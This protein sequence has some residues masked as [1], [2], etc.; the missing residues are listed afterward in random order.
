MRRTAGL[1]LLVA[2]GLVAC[3]ST[4]D[5]T[6]ANVTPD[7]LA[8]TPA[9]DLSP[10]KDVFETSLVAKE[11]VKD[12]GGP[13]PTRVWTYGGTMPGPLVDVNVGDELVAH[14]RNE[15]P[16]PTL[17]HWHGLR[18][19]AAMDGSPSVQTPVKPGESFDYRFRLKDAGLFWFHPHVRTGEQ[20]ERGLAGVIRVRGADEPDV[21]DERILVLDDVKLGDDGQ[22]PSYVDD[23]SKMLGREADTI[24]VNGV[25]DAVLSARPGALLRLR[26]LDVANGRFFNLKIA[27]ARMTVIG[28][29]GGRVAEPYETETVLLAPAERYDVV[30]RVP[31]QPGDLAITTE[32]YERGHDT[33]KNPAKKVATLRIQGEPVTTEKPL[34]KGRPIEKL[35]S[36]TGA[37]VKF[38]LDEG[39]TPQGELTFTLNGKAW[40]EV[41]AERVGVGEVRLLELENHAEMDHPFHVHGT[42]FQV[43][44]VNGVPASRLVEKDTVIVP[45]KGKVTAVARF[46]EPG[47]WMV[48]CHINEHSDSGMMGEI[49]VGDAVS[50]AHGA[51]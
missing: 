49:L 51:H 40:P 24:L 21:D 8:L 29:D 17:V 20:V 10:A 43:L 19:P 34:P 47:A 22:F 38:V 39:T 13:K 1:A 32:P 31:K 18:L 50:K 7:P 6:N 25:R 9:V 15:L 46:D 37:A 45:M 44:S 33:G 11:S 5:T 3:G 42:F 12:L 4:N 26:L 23:A 35:P 48:H 27:G 14:F 28:T 16:E 41:P 36:P 30:V 2:T